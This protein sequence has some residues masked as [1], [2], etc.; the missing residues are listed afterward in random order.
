ME[1]AHGW[2]YQRSKGRAAK[3]LGE[4]DSKIS[5][6]HLVTQALPSNSTSTT[7]DIFYRPSASE[8]FYT[9]STGIG[10]AID[11]QEPKKYEEKMSYLAAYGVSPRLSGP[12]A[13]DGVLDF[14]AQLTSMASTTRTEDFSLAREDAKDP[15]DDFAR[16]DSSSVSS[17]ANRRTLQPLR[18]PPLDLLPLSIPTSTT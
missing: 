12:L 9:P 7:P 2:Q 17:H 13:E 11:A 15:A 10:L 14:P 8:I 16:F 18:L 3:E 4:D 5:Q 1:K 6:S